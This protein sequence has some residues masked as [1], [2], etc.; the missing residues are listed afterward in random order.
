M[1]QPWIIIAI[2][3]IIAL[4]G[5]FLLA[6][7]PNFLGTQASPTPLIST[8]PTP[9]PSA[10]LEMVIDLDEQNE[11]SQSG[12]VM[13]LEENG[14]VK[15]SVDLSNVPKG[16]SQPAHIHIGACPTPGDVKYPLT[17][18]VDGKSETT[19]N[20]T[21]TKLLSELPLAVNVHK[22]AA[23]IKTYVACGNLES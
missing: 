1:K 18:V 8:T 19:L 22:S 15:V 16:V 6:R 3:I 23:D 7:S 4:L 2:I 20:T 12:T 9:S 14:K 13:L 10:Q 11:S 17:N 5:V 21:L